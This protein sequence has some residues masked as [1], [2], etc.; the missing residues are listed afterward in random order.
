MWIFF[1][2]DLKNI[3]LNF[4]YLPFAL[5][6]GVNDTYLSRAAYC[7]KILCNVT[8]WCFLAIFWREAARSVIKYGEQIMLKFSPTSGGPFTNS[9]DF[10]IQM[11]VFYY[12]VI[13]Q[14][15]CNLVITTQVRTPKHDSIQCRGVADGKE[16]FFTKLRRTCLQ[17]IKK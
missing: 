5:Q 10:W 8:L 14:W 3:S 6:T 16:I 2:L 17:T 1:S 12:F 7:F 15:K 13:Q 9:C 4:F 11:R